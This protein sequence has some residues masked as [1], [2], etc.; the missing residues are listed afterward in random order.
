MA[1]I[2]TIA[3]IACHGGP[4]DHFATY[5]KALTEQGYNVEICAS[6]PALK[7][8]EQCNAKVNYR[9]DLDNKT[10]KEQDELAQRIADSCSSASMV[11][12]D[13]GHGFDVKIH[14]ALKEKKI[15]HFAYYDNPENFVPGGYTCHNCIPRRGLLLKRSSI[16]SP[17]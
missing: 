2:S 16:N 3:F 11:I 10:P 15:T 8:F 13:V 9:F 12:T 1:V 5:A 17:I 14:E 4:A 6:G 7:K